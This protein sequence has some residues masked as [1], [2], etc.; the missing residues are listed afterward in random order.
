MP[1]NA[2]SVCRPGRWGNP[3]KIGSPHPMTGLPISQQDAVD[4]FVTLMD[5]DWDKTLWLSPLKSMDLACW[6]SLD[7]PCHADILI[8]WANE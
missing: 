2:I 1:D 8:K 5:G 4:L 3:Y 6:C 7:E